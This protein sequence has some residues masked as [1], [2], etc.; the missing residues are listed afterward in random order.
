MNRY[1][2]ILGG[3]LNIE[4]EDDDQLDMLY[5]STRRSEGSNRGRVRR[6]RGSVPGRR[7]INRGRVEG[8]E[9]LYHDYF[10]TPC[11]Y[12]GFFRRRFRMSRHLFLRIANEVEQHDPYFIQTIDAVGVLGLSSIQKITAAYRILAY[13]T[14]VDFVDEY[15]RIGENTAILSLR[16]FVKAIIAVFD[17][18]YLRP[19]NNSDITRLLQ[20]GEQRG[21]PG[22]LGSIDCMHWKWKNC[23]TAWQGMYTGHCHEPTIILEAVASQDL[24]IWHAFFGLPGS[25]NDINVLDRSPIFSLLANGHAPPVNYTINGHEY[26]MV[27]YLTDG[28][29]P[30][31]ST[32]VKTIPCPQGLKKKHFAKGQES[33]RKDVERAFEVLQ[34][35][36]AIVRGPVRFWDEQTLADIMK[37]CIIMHNMVIE[38]EGDI[39]NNDFDG[40]NANPPVEVS[41]AYTPELEDFMQ[42]HCQ[43]RDI[44]THSQLQSDLIEHLWE[45]H[46]EE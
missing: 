45:L 43:I 44:V 39:G 38:D 28:I 40:S 46:G 25:L 33:A 3:I 35:R 8:H 36:F 34:A 2:N 32:F 5:D 17:D 21:F 18:H 20:I 27:Y 7:T 30:N 37:A 11:V 16:R 23:P 6:H 26:T 15:I 29:Y 12:E 10:A 22:M 13:G 1:P 31:W 9:R 41:H 24:W 19:P 4:E 14:P 42:T